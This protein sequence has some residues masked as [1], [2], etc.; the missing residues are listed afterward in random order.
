MAK[1]RNTKNKG[2]QNVSKRKWPREKLIALLSWLDF[3]L[4]HEEISFESTVVD[5]LDNS[6][7]FMQ[8]RRKLPRLWETYGPNQEPGGPK[9]EC[10]IEIRGS[11]TLDNP[12]GLTDDEKRDIA[13]AVEK[14]ENG[15]SARQHTQPSRLLRSSSRAL[16]ISSH[17]R[18]E[19]EIRR[20]KTEELIQGRKPRLQTSSVTPSE[21]TRRT[22]INAKISKKAVRKNSRKKIAQR[23]VS[24]KFSGAMLQ[25]C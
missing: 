7:T 20:S 13:L 14:L 19:S 18:V 6:Y 8:I 23:N 2:A 16:L 10:D 25:I 3:T 4:R 5:Y 15:Y 12:H 9:P 1:Q 22:N 24:Y 17:Q 11:K 21:P